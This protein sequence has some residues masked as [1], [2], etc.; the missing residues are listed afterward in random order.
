MLCVLE[1]AEDAP[2]TLRVPLV[3]LESIWAIASLC[4][5][6]A[7]LA[8]RRTTVVVLTLCCR[9][10]GSV[11]GNGVRV[12]RPTPVIGR[13][14]VGPACQEP[15]GAWGGPGKGYTGGGAGG[16][17]GGSAARQPLVALPA[18]MYGTTSRFAS[19]SSCA[20]VR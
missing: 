10:V 9:S 5:I 17:A 20:R 12:T 15:A 2:A 3:P 8:R 11:Y 18:G 6:Q 13:R 1:T 14:R 4:R 19:A 7:R 16:R